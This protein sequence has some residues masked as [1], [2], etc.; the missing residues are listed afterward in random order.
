MLLNH[1]YFCGSLIAL[2]VAMLCILLRPKQL[3]G[4][5]YSGL[6]SVP[7]AAFV[8]VYKE[9]WR[10]NTIFDWL[11]NPEDIIWTFSM[12]L[13]AWFIY[14]GLDKKCLQLNPFRI[15]K[16]KLFVF[17]RLSLLPLASGVLF[18]I[19]FKNIS[20]ATL[21]PIFIMIGLL[22]RRSRAQH[23]FL[24]G[25]FFAAYHIIGTA[26]FL[27]IWPEAHSY[28]IK[29]NELGFRIALIPSYEIL[30]AP[31]FGACW[32]LIVCFL[33]KENAFAHTIKEEISSP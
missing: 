11:I 30:W 29:P 1:P 8:I 4:L 7:N 21:L 27:Q 32:P 25:F 16:K 24:S 13:L 3:R 15:D 18:Y 19:F 26:V 23:I 31:L 10:P 2:L 6:L 28:W 20:I 12:G 33:Q 5:L 22:Y 17:L 14:S 9:I